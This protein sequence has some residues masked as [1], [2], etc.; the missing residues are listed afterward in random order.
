MGMGEKAVHYLNM[1]NPINHALDQQASP[2]PTRWN[3]LW[4]SRI[5][6]E[7]SSHGTGRLV[8][9]HRFG[10]MDVSG[11]PGVCARPAIEWG[12]HSAEARN[13]GK[14]ERIQHRPEA[15]G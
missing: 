7:K 11:G 3:P 1:I 4:W 12:L 2:T 10:R 5:S 8:L 14:L 6:T 9:V 15:G 13:F